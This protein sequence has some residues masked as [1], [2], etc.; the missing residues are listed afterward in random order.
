LAQN[1]V[2]RLQ[3]LMQFVAAHSNTTFRER[4]LQQQMQLPGT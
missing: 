4:M 2:V 1:Q 3:E